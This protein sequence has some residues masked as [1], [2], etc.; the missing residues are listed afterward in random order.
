MKTAAVDCSCSCGENLK[1]ERLGFVNPCC[2]GLNDVSI[3]RVDGNRL[4]VSRDLWDQWRKG[5]TQVFIE[6]PRTAA[7]QTDRQRQE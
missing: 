7:S 6:N 4:L 2:D 1:G 5:C 3:R